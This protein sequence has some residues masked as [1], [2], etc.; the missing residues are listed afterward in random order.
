LS[1]SVGLVL[2]A[3]ADVP[4]T[5][6]TISASSSDGASHDSSMA[7]DGD[8]DTWWQAGSSAKGEWLA[9]EFRKP[10][11]VRA[12]RISEARTAIRAWRIEALGNGV[13]RSIVSGRGI[14]LKKVDIP[15]TWAEGIRIVFTGEASAAP[16]ITEFAAWA[17][18]SSACTPLPNVATTLVAGDLDCAGLTLS[19]PCGIT[20]PG[21][22]L[23]VLQDGARLRNVTLIDSY[24]SCNGACT[25]E[26]VHWRSQCKTS[27]DMAALIQSYT[28][29][30]RRD[31][32]VIGSSAMGK[33]GALFHL[34]TPDSTLFVRQFNFAGAADSLTGVA[35][36]LS[37][38]LHYDLDGISIGGEIRRGIA[39]VRPHMGDT[40]TLRNLRIFNYRPGSP[41]LC[42]SYRLF[43]DKP[44]LLGEQWGSTN[45]NVSDSD[46]RKQ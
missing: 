43:G 15:P 2:P 37:Q 21:S 29:G 34:N 32:R 31:V 3:R 22:P 16:A 33:F 40:A 35:Q 27:V 8:P 12:L 6:A 30:G 9:L 39:S 19:Q 38:R 18:G 7:A 28:N 23:F 42:M 26:N 10:A 46:V 24:V 14:P 44:Q 36:D 20:L 45:C 5:G 17:S 41:A 4:V 25:M 13:W 1:L 11:L